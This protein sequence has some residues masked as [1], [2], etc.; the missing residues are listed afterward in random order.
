MGFLIIRILFL[1]LSLLTGGYFAPKLNIPHAG[2]LIAL[3]IACII[4]AV[5]ILAK[6]ISLRGLSSAF[7]GLL[8]GII[9]AKFIGYIIDIIVLDEQI[10]LF[11]NTMML[12]ILSYIGLMLG[13]KGRDDFHIVIPY[14]RFKRQD[15]KADL[16]IMDTSAIIDGRIID[17][18][19]TR[20]I[21]ST[22]VA[23]RFVLEELQKISDSTDVVKRQRGKRGLE[24][25]NELKNIE[26]VSFKVHQEDIEGI[27]S[28]D[29]KLIKLAKI[30]DSKI[31]TTDYNLNRLAELEGIKV[32][33]VNDL[34]NALK[35]IFLPGERIP[36]KLTK[37]GKEYNQ[38]VGYLEDGTMVVVENAKWLIN[39]NV[40]VEVVSVLQSPSGRIIFTKLSQEDN[41]RQH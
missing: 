26:G 38:G 29:A 25:L 33:N 3:G 24:I 5:E 10:R 19:K 18:V 17:V 27:K 34:A 23:P 2:P 7:F 8:L 22:L 30:L 21:E 12:L 14:V 37:E 41:H 15:V 11:G 32:L 9:F 6:K 35:A 28:V 39:K 1:L 20:F 16:L 36:I 13:L 31:L 4:L 40:T